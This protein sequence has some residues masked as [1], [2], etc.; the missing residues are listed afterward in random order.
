VYTIG[1]YQDM[2]TL[3]MQ[4]RDSLYDLLANEEDSDS[5][6]GPV[7]WP[8]E[9]PP[10]SDSLPDANTTKGSA[11][12]TI[13]GRY[14]DMAPPTPPF[15]GSFERE[16]GSTNSSLIRAK[17]Q[18]PPPLTIVSTSTSVS[19]S[20]DSVTKIKRAQL[21]PGMKSPSGNA[22][23]SARRRRA[24]K[25]SRFFGVGYN[26][27]FNVLVYETAAADGQSSLAPPVPLLPSS[28][29]P[30]TP[31]AG[32]S[33]ASRTNLT[34]PGTSGDNGIRS[35]TVLVQT[36]AGKSTVLRTSSNFAADIDA[37]DLGEVMARLR[38]L[39]A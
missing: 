7:E 19:A 18:R 14:P 5:D 28:S 10:R 20:N 32:P 6:Q 12:Y 37:D 15:E 21:T 34:V 33:S 39:R 23:F 31:N 29:S 3:R 9:G 11:K 30:S 38:A 17:S 36:D 26:D 22:Q 2:L 8:Y 27:L 25:L 16:I 24:H 13:A 35:G 1:S 4:D